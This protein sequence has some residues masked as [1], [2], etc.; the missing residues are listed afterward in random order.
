MRY[1]V[2]TAVKKSTVVSWVLT[3]SGLLGGNQRFGK[4]DKDGVTN[5]KVTADIGNEV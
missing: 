5:Q 3:S 1:E 4:D 2:L